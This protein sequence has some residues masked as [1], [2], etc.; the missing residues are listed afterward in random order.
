MKRIVVA[1]LL[2]GICSASALAQA[3]N[4]RASLEVRPQSGP[5][6]TP[7][8]QLAELRAEVAL[9]R[10][11][12]EQRMAS[13]EAQLEDVQ[14]QM[15]RAAPEEAA[16]PAPASASQTAYSSLNPSISVIGNF[17]ARGDSD[18]IFSPEGDRIDN[19]L[20]LRE[21]EI[22]FRVPVDPYADAV[23]IAAFESEAPGSFEAGIEEG[24]INIKK[25]PFMSNPLGLRF[26]VGRFRPDFGRFN[27][28]HTHDLPQ[29]FR[30]MSTTEFLGEEG[31]IQQ[32]L[33]AE[34]YVP[35][36]W[37]GEDS[38]NAELQIINGGDIAFSPESNGKKAY[39]GKITWF[40]T[41]DGTHNLE[42]GWSSYWHPGGESESTARLHAA[43]FMYK[44]KPF[45]Q[46]EWNSYVLGGE[47]MYTDPRR[48][49]VDPDAPL[50]RPWG[51]SV[52]T[53]W[54][55][56]RRKYV[57]IRADY[58]ESL[59]EPGKTRRGV[60]PYL[61]YYMSEFFRLRLNYEHRWSDILAEDGRNSVFLEFN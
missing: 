29:S 11:E 1:I 7:A 41:F 25:L 21:T 32:G 20:N 59:S 28:L 50:S 39:L 53:Q 38:L 40:N 26:K 46:G 35:K 14:I 42:L 6:P 47:V 58:T 30:S 36:P 45:R 15:L 34:F 12:Y 5:D 13:L 33:S 24:Y 17:L 16:S 61:P 4:E 44:W 8:E 49:S 19:N 57:G 54:Q 10:D 52:F 31:F 43:D 22:D 60:T 2:V 56:D 51:G 55:L 37:R 27:V 18:R 3:N 48:S 23:L 9:L